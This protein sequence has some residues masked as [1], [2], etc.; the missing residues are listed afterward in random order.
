VAPNEQRN[1]RENRVISVVIAHTATRGEDSMTGWVLVWVLVVRTGTAF[2]MTPHEKPMPSFDA[3]TRAKI[4]LETELSENPVS[5]GDFTSFSARCEY[6]DEVVE[7]H[8]PT[9]EDFLPR[10]YPLSDN[11]DVNE[12]E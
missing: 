4:E 5:W 12:H 8:E 10:T 6:K 7:Y 1:Q 9:S 11:L 3:C 2:V